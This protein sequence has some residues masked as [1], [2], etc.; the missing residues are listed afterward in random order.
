MPIPTDS[1]PSLQAATAYAFFFDVDGTLA[2]I[3][4]RPDEVSIPASVLDD[5]QWL[6]Q[7]CD[8][9]VALISGRPIVELDALAA[10]LV[11]P[12]AGVHGAERRDVDGNI[13]RVALAPH[14]VSTLQRELE[15]AIASLPGA[16]LETKGA[17]FA[18]HYRQAPQHQQQIEQL[19]ASMMARFPEL[20]QQPG[21]CVVELKPQDVN[22]GAAI[23]QFMQLPPFACRV[24]VF[25]GDDLTDEAGFNAVNAIGGISIKVGTGSSEARGHLADVNAVYRWLVQARKQLDNGAKASLRSQSYESLSS[26]I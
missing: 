24:P 18:L 15:Q 6:A 23:N 3:Q 21:K 2:A 22:K 26:R 12:M 8:G 4:S 19:A 1:V 20:A 7:H 5:L 13:T 14:T 17:A 11:L 9:A 16:M 10:P 25:L